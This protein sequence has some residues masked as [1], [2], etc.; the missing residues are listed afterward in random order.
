RE[1][2]SSCRVK[3]RSMRFASIGIP[4]ASRS[5]RVEDTR[6]GFTLLEALVALAL[7]LAFA[8]TLG[9]YLFYSRRIMVDSESRLAA[10]VL[11]RTLLDARLDRGP[12]ARASREGEVGKLRGRIVTEPVATA[13]AGRERPVWPAFRVAVTVG[14]GPD[15]S[16]TA[17]TVRLGKLE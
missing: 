12:R 11:L 7:L 5:S 13:A 9:P 10:P 16:V 17:E 2:C 1:R 4:A 8:S 3:R 15:Q 14:W 6:A